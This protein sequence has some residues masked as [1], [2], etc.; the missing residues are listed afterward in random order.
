MDGQPA[1][2]H[3][4]ESHG[5][6]TESIKQELSHYHIVASGSLLPGFMI[7]QT[8]SYGSYQ[9]FVLPQLSQQTV[10]ALWA[11]MLFDSIALLETIM[12][13]AGESSSPEQGAE[14]R[15]R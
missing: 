6:S 13:D 7:S 11:L 15:L 4:I 14:I 2:P 9:G 8:L 12:P 3:F 5:G 1:W 10:N